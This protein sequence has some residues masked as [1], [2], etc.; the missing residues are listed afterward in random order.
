MTIFLRQTRAVE[1]FIGIFL[2]KYII[3]VN[4]KIFTD[5]CS[6]IDEMLSLP[7]RN[8]SLTVKKDLNESVMTC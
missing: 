2:C 7:S 4:N 8:T 6:F 1:K 3:Q 5:V